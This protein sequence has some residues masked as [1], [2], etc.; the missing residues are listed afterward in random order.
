MKWKNL[1]IVAAIFAALFSWV[2]FYEIKGEKTREEAAEK[3]KKIFQF[4]EKDIAQI[5][6]QESRR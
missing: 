4:E 5:D 1:A 6:R 2:Y 3:E